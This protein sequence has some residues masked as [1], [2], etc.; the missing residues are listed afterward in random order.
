MAAGSLGQVHR[1]VHLDGRPLAVKIRRPNVVRD[2]ERD[3][4]LM[5]E[6]AILIERHLPEAEIFDPVG[7]V[8]QFARTIRREINFA[9]EGRTMDEFRRLFRN[10]ATLYIPRVCW[11]LTT[12]A[13][14]TME[15]VEGLKIGDRD[16]AGCR[17]IWPGGNRRQRRPDFHED[18]VRVRFFSRRPASRQSCGSCR[19]A[20]SA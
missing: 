17:G 15:F 14:L 4:S 20:S 16:G 10:D 12:E 7:L 13:M 1:A 19:T 2:V 5:T 9:R 18:G 11:E 8:N 6:M 3:L